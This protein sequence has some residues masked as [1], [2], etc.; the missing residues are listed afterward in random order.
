MNT[1]S[2]ISIKK[3]HG[4]NMEAM[5]LYGPNVWHCLPISEDGPCLM[6]ET[7]NIFS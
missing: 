1:Q 6:E 7:G 3:G 2:L 5:D 4:S